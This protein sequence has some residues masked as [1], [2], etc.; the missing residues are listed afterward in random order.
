MLSI[1]LV[2]ERT[3]QNGIRMKFLQFIHTLWS[4]FKQFFHRVYTM[5]HFVVVGILIICSVHRLKMP[6]Y[7]GKNLVRESK[8]EKIGIR[9]LV[10]EL[11]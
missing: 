11:V 5:F 7:L 3:L 8:E 9:I 10:A 1:A 2:S 4:L 6:I